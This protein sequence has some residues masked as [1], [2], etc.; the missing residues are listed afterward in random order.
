MFIYL[1]KI[2]PKGIIP[3]RYETKKIFDRAPFPRLVM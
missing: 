3:L 2:D 1:E